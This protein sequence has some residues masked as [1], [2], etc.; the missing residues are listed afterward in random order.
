MKLSP[1]TS[2]FGTFQDH[3]FTKDWKST[4]VFKG[5]SD[6]F[7]ASDSVCRRVHERGLKACCGLLLECSVWKNEERLK[8]N[9]HLKPG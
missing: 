8:S 3:P 2:Y 9:Y 7:P 6:W 1:Q 4:A 5:H